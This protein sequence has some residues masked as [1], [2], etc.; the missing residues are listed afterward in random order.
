MMHGKKFGSGKPKMMFGPK[1]T[2]TESV[3]DVQQDLDIEPPML[4]FET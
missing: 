1:P 3:D 4:I 2:V